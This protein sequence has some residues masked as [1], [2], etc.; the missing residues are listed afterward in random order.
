MTAANAR[1]SRALLLDTNV[2]LD[3]LLRREPWATEAVILLDAL[4]R[5]AAR[6]FIS[7]HSFTT[8]HYIVERAAG[9]PAA[10]TAVSDV[11][12][13]LDVVPLDRSDF[14]RALTLG[15]ADYED[16]VQV[17]AYLRSGADYLVSRDTKHFRTASVHLHPPGEMVAILTSSR[18]S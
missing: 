3:V 4:N 18:R 5:G 1:R 9:R 15:V 14:Q 6:G 12:H 10:R 11:L 7:A 8:V 16:A 2:I 13:I 17:A